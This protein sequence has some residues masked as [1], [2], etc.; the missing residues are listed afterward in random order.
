MYCVLTVRGP[1]VY[2]NWRGFSLADLR[3]VI[4]RVT[5]LH[6]ALGRPVVYLARIPA[7]ARIFSQDEHSA[8]LEFLAAILP[9][10]ATIHHVIE[11]DGFIK[12]ARQA[13]V[14]NMAAATSRPRAF[15][16][17]ATFAAAASLIG[18][19]HNVDLGPL[20]KERDRDD[21]PSSA[22][23]SSVRPLPSSDEVE[24][25]SGAFR[26]ARRI[27]ADGRKPK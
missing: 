2:A 23:E 25:A 17:H 24:R 9:H 11:G 27:A 7:S 16:T 20:V 6:A 26:L 5:A 18:E 1:V 22:D 14:M 8:L 19:M 21:A 10:C 15:Y 12:S 4:D 13:V 3:N